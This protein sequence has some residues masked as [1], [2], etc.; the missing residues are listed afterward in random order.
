MLMAVLSLRIL[1]LHDLID[2]AYITVHYAQNLAA[3][4]GW[5]WNEGSAPTDGTTAPLWT[6]VLSVVLWLHLPLV[7]SALMLNAICYAAF[8]A[9]ACLLA[10][11]VGGWVSAGICLLGMI[12]FSNIL[13]SCAGMETTLYLVLLVGSFL[14]WHARR[15]GPALLVAGLLPL[16]RGDGALLLAVLGIE[17]IIERRVR[18]L[19]PTALLALIPIASWE[20]FSIW[21]FHS[22]LPNSFLAK[23]ATS[24]GVGGKV[25]LLSFLTAL[26]PGESAVYLWL[27]GGIGAA[28]GRKIPVVR[29]MAIWM[30]AYIVFYARFAQVPQQ[31]WYVAPAWWM[32]PILTALGV[33]LTI[34]D[35]S[36]DV[37]IRR[38]VWAI[39]AAAL[40]VGFLAAPP[41]LRA[42]LQDGPLLLSTNRQAA[43]Y[44]AAR[45]RGL[46]A[47]AEVGT[48]GTYSHD[49]VVDILG[50]V[51]P[52]VVPHLVRRDYGW[53]IRR[54][55]PR[56]VFLWTMPR[57]GCYSDVTCEVWS[58]SWFR[59]HYHA[60]WSRPSGPGDS[61]AVLE[62][63]K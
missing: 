2:D 19:W 60:V 14:L 61:Y 28:A 25:T 39:P 62:Y 4:H 44:L 53:I 31:S 36:T 23:H 30:A 27:A 52:E 8:A 3:G 42:A 58:S 57:I 56:Y 26:Y 6:V 1:W 35:A 17:A 37:T 7:E 48:I 13:P 40:L 9:L 11:R 33:G 12:A 59:E 20:V 41:L 43:A 22:L 10:S 16:V 21:E 49:P 38:L 54:D 45:P 47:A 51:S 50:L 34:R 15:Y 24:A 18:D 46:V 55:R 5:V 63:R 29:A 32:L